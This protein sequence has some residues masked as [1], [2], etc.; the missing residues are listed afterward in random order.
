MSLEDILKVL[1]D[2][3]QQPA[4]SQGADPMANL[5]GSLLSGGRPQG[6][7]QSGGSQPSG[8]GDMMGMLE[9]VMGSQS[10]P[11]NMGT[12]DPIMALLQPFVKQLANK[13]DISPEIAMVVI[14]FV[15]HKLLSHHPTSKR[16]SNSF[17]LDDMLQQMGTGQVDSGLLRSSSMV[18]ELSKK[19]GLDEGTTEKSLQLALGLL[20]NIVNKTGKPSVPTSKTRPSRTG[21]KPRAKGGKR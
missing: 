8:L 7:P 4:S 15:V 21:L 11:S 9:T 12:G 3:R 13:M 17:N 10:G 20:G 16:D 19:T 2:S 18:A 14:S 5:I 1:V 6:M